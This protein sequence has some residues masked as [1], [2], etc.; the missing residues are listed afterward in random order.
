MATMMK[1][2]CGISKGY[3]ISRVSERVGKGRERQ[4]GENRRA[5]Q[6]TLTHGVKFEPLTTVRRGR[7]EKE[8]GNEKERK[9]KG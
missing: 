6:V 5:S 3:H 8:R 7:T 9:R 2:G 4:R 1:P